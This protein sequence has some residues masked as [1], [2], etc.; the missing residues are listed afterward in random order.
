MGFFKRIKKQISRSVR[1]ISKQAKRTIS[2][3]DLEASRLTKAGRE[4]QRTG[5][6]ALSRLGKNVARGLTPAVKQVTGIQLRRDITKASGK[7]AAE[8]DL[9]LNIAMG[10]GSGGG[11]GFF[12][13]IFSAATK[14]ATSITTQSIG[15]AI[16]GF[17]GTV[18]KEVVSKVAQGAVQTFIG[19]NPKLG[20]LFGGPPTTGQAR[21]IPVALPGRLPV[22]IGG[23]GAVLAGGAATDLLLRGGKAVFDRASGFFGPAPTAP[24]PGRTVT[25]AAP[26]RGGSSM[27]LRAFHP[28]TPHATAQQHIAS[29]VRQ[30]AVR[31][32][33]AIGEVILMPDGSTV[34]V[35]KK[36]RRR[37]NPLNP[38]ALNRAFR[39]VEGFTKAVKRAKKIARRVKF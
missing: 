28:H 29:T 27:G 15:R 10:L 4:F 19:K 38:R 7:H 13:D 17:V 39:R 5:T 25:R 1:S 2:K 33:T 36:K 34:F 35:H 20:R 32:P 16:G 3:A 24:L 22:Q 26:Q 9:A 37:M 30:L 8:V 31:S 14:G 6:R 12:G 18:G 23:F 11:I 21:S